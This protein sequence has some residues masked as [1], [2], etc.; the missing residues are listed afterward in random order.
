MIS[1]GT[2][3]PETHPRR[4]PDAAYQVSLY[5]IN[6][7]KQF[8]SFEGSTLALFML[9]ILTNDTDTAFSL[10]DLALFADRFYRRSYLHDESSFLKSDT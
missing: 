9:W 1:S 3:Y 10:D 7:H 5:N 6:A 8:R 2:V 4:Y